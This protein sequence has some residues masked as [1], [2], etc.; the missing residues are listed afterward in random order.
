MSE[1]NKTKIEW[2]I[3]QRAIWNV[4][5]TIN[6]EK[7]TVEFNKGYMKGRYDAL[8]AIKNLLPEQL[9]MRNERRR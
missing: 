4:Q 3:L 6:D 9:V 5:N 2:D 8:V 7:C 1:I